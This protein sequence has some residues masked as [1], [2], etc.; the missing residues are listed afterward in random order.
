MADDNGKLKVRNGLQVMEELL[1]EMEKSNQIMWESAELQGR[2]YR[3][4]LL[5]GGRNIEAAECYRAKDTAV[6]SEIAAL[7]YAACSDAFS[8]YELW[9]GTRRIVRGKGNKTFVTP[10]DP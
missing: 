4:Y 8:G 5:N 6:A 7:L 10:D 3:F 9:Q 1:S 2:I